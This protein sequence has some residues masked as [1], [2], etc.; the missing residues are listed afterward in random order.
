MN[1]FT[2]YKKKKDKKGIIAVGTFLV[3]LFVAGVLTGSVI[4]DARSTGEWKAD[5]TQSECAMYNPRTQ[6]FEMLR[7]KG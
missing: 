5:T 1:S 6:Q 7:E 4:Q 2:D 3:A